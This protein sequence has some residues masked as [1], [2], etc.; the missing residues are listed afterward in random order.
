MDDMTDSTRLTLLDVVLPVV[1]LRSKDF[2][3]RW[4]LI[5]AVT[6]TATTT[7]T[8]QRWGEITTIDDM[9]VVPCGVASV[10]VYFVLAILFLNW[11]SLYCC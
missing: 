8:A 7:T 2:P 3:F 1:V 6:L 11:P 4:T 5:I 9:V 10:S